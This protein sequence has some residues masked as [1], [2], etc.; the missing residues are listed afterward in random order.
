MMNLPKSYEGNGHVFGKARNHSHEKIGLPGPGDYKIRDS[1][2]ERKGGIISSG[3]NYGR[4]DNPSPGP[5]MYNLKV[6][7]TL[8][9]GYSIAHGS[10]S[11]RSHLLPGPADYHINVRSSLSPVPLTIAKSGRDLGRTELPLP[12]PGQYGASSTQEKHPVGPRV[13]IGRSP[14]FV[15]KG[16]LSPGPADYTNRSS[17]QIERSPRVP[18]P[19]ARKAP[20]SPMMVTP[21]PASYNLPTTSNLGPKL[22]FSRSI[23]HIQQKDPPVGELYNIPAAYPNAPIY[24][25]KNWSVK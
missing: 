4:D 24:H 13:T 21:G 3:R 10:T 6:D 20:N 23:R 9:R 12:G 18:I 8:H 2:L 15:R 1:Y 5:G 14:R 16:D 22:S 11:S 25:V 17:V 7:T 19:Q